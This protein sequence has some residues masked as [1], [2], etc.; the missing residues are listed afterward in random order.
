MLFGGG[1]VWWLATVD[2]GVRGFDDCVV[3]D[4]WEEGEQA[5]RIIG[6]VFVVG[7]FFLLILMVVVLTGCEDLTEVKIQEELPVQA[8][9]P[10]SCPTPAEGAVEPDGIPRVDPN[11]K[12]AM[13][14]MLDLTAAVAGD[15]HRRIQT[16]EVIVNDNQLRIHEL[17]ENCVVRPLVFGVEW[18]GLPDDHQVGSIRSDIE[19]ASY[20]VGEASRETE[21]VAR[22]G[23]IIM[24]RFYR[25][26][27]TITFGTKKRFPINIRLGEETEQ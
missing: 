12:V 16:V 24:A 19:G 10:T 2:F 17:M 9:A 23:A 13:A 26:G 7:M 1:G 20:R 27:I 25:E 11:D 15:N 3:D 6:S 21:N 18:E 22:W 5:M 14:A 8:P 4:R